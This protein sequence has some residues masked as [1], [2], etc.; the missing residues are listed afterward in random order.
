VY[1]NNRKGTDDG[2]WPWDWFTD[3][4]GWWLNSKSLLASYDGIGRR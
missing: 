3:D 1:N 4:D 2:M